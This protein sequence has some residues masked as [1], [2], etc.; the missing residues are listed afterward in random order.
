MVSRHGCGLIIY[1]K[2]CTHTL[3]NG[4]EKQARRSLTDFGAMSVLTRRVGSCTL[5]RKIRGAAQWT[6]WHWGEN[7][8][9][10]P[11]QRC[12]RTCSEREHADE[13]KGVSYCHIATT[14]IAV[15]SCTYVAD[16]PLIH[17]QTKCRS[18]HLLLPCVNSSDKCNP[19][20][21]C[22]SL[23]AL[24]AVYKSNFQTAQFHSCYILLQWQRF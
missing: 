7:L 11:Q 15:G 23:A 12:C 18:W 21:L 16:L 14:H 17:V 22:N 24:S 13:K 8:F 5:R 4:N 19:S 6:Y 2:L 3:P 9:P 10:S 20:T 1:T